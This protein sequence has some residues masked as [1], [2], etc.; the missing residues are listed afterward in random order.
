ME[1]EELL[2]DVVDPEDELL[3]EESVESV[4]L[5]E[6]DSVPLVDPEEDIVVE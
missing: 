2:E 6:L 3:D 4:V 1:Y 5:E